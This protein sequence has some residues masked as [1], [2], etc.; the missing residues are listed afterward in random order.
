MRNVIW[1]FAVVIAMAG[2]SRFLSLTED[3]S[4]TKASFG[5]ESGVVVEVTHNIPSGF[6][7]F[8]ATQPAGKAGATTPSKF[9]AKEEHGV[10]EGV[11]TG[12]VAV[13]VAVGVGEGVPV[14]VAVAVGVGDG[15]PLEITSVFVYRSKACNVPFGF[16]P[17]QFELSAHTV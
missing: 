1:G 6:T 15:V 16:V 4:L 3:G 11:G 8:D 2:V 10:G 17:S 9:S 14:E 12:T 5:G 13:A 7:A